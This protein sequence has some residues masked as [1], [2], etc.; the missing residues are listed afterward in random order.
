[1][2]P[3]N[4]E[5]SVFRIQGLGESEIWELGRKRL[6]SIHGRAVILVRA[7]Q[8]TSLRVIP[9]KPSSRHANIVGWPREK[10][11]QMSLA[12]QLAAQA[13]LCL[14]GQDERAYGFPVA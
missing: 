8:E 5:L 3:D 11:Q 9:N 10:E 6:R 13:E 1:M 7:V 14:I 2:P 12:Q 4:L